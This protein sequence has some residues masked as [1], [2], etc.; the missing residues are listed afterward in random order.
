MHTVL[1]VGHAPGIPAT[2]AQLA[3]TGSS[4]S[5]ADN[6]GRDHPIGVPRTDPTIEDLR[7]FTAGAIAVLETDVQL[8][9]PAGRRVRT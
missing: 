7:H 9:P 5:G 4:H 8:G 2:A 3:A 1:V 6:V